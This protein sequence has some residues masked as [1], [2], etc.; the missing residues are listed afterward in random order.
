MSL[1]LQAN[2][3]R[4]LSLLMQAF[5]TVNRTESI[6]HKLTMMENFIALDITNLKQMQ[7]LPS[8]KAQCLYHVV[9]KVIFQPEK[10]MKKQFK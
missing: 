3:E 8:T 1:H 2:T 6:R 5:H 9:S 7:R 10:N 4:N